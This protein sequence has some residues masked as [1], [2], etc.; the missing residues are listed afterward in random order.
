MN[1]F[2]RLFGGAD[3]LADG[4]DTNRRSSTSRRASYRSAS[5]P[6][7]FGSP[8]PTVPDKVV[9]FS[10]GGQ[11]FSTRASTLR[12][13]SGS[14]FA[15]LADVLHPQGAIA[16]VSGSDTNEGPPDAATSHSRLRR[17]PEIDVT[18][19][20]GGRVFID[21]DPAFLPLI[22]KYLRA[23]ASQHA[24][25]LA[26]LGA[27]RRGTKEFAELVF[28]CRFYRL[29]G[30]LSMLDAEEQASVVAAA[31]AQAAM[32]P[33]PR[34]VGLGDSVGKSEESMF[35]ARRTSQ[36]ST[37]VP[38]QQQYSVGGTTLPS[39]RDEDGNST[40][41]GEKTLQMLLVKQLLAEG[42]S[43][44]ADHHAEM[45][46]LL[47]QIKIEDQKE[48]YARDKALLERKN[49]GKSLK[50]NMIVVG[51]TGTGMYWINSLIH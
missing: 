11:V 30:L 4:T 5:P 14:L 8:P 6:S 16:Q 3:D 29:P 43:G 12:C 50:Y 36:W 33:P 10:V 51:V 39:V 9:D 49:T 32:S 1:V 26:H 47:E 45:D 19:D 22:L 41:T 42:D 31:A 38:R 28:E 13:E 48:R 15:A 27:P 7:S 23:T 25:T 46:R 18:L 20:G 40:D 37:G 2:N 24:L 17:A 35:G 21:R 44:N 34:L